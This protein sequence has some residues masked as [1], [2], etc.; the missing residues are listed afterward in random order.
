MEATIGAPTQAY[1]HLILGPAT[2]GLHGAGFISAT[3]AIAVRV[4][5]TTVPSYIGVEQGNPNRLYGV[6]WI[7][8]LTQVGA[9]DR[10]IIKFTR[11]VFYLPIGTA[12]IQ[13]FFE[14]G[15]VATLTLVDGTL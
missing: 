14:P 4:D 12:D 10:F 7:T 8:P 6:G 11:E 13:Y 1:G 15:V 3:G 2:A 9:A 5:L